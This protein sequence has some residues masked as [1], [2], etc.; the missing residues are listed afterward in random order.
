MLGIVKTII[1]RLNVN[2]TGGVA[3]VWS[4]DR[5]SVSGDGGK[6]D[7]TTRGGSTTAS[8]PHLYTCPSCEDVFIATDKRTC[9]TCDVPV[10]RLE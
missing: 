5:T 4:H 2:S 10:D 8:P 7:Y 1:D 3:A 6:A 9:S